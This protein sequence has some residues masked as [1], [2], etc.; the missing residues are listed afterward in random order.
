[1][2]SDGSLTAFSKTWYHGFDVTLAPQS[3]VLSYN[4]AML[5][6]GGTP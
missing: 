5:A 2:H 3:G 1:M 6:V 4:D